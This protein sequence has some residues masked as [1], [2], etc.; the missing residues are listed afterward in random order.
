MNRSSRSFERIALIIASIVLT[1]L[2]AEAL[3]RLLGVAPPPMS[4]DSEA[5][6]ATPPGKRILD[7]LVPG[8]T[9][10]FQGI[11]YTLNRLG[12]RGPEYDPWPAPGD[13][14]IVIVGDSVTMGHG[15]RAG[16]TYPALVEASLNAK[17]D[18]RRY[19]VINLGLSNLNSASVMNRL[20][21]IGASYH[22]DLVVYGY[23][24]NDIEGTDYRNTVRSPDGIA[25]RR[26][27]GWRF[28]DSSSALARFLWPRLVDLSEILFVPRGSY[29]YELDDNYFDNPAAW[30]TV[31]NSLSRLARFA[32]SRRNCAHV[33]VHT[34]VVHINFHNPFIPIYEKV[35]AAAEAHGMT[36]TRSLPFFLGHDDRTL[37]VSAFD[38]HPNAAGHRLHA[39]ALLDGLA[40]LPASCW[41]SH[42]TRA[43][44]ATDAA[45]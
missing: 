30:S 43:S 27:F 36:V 11:E 7:I 28:R 1:C 42:L 38:P 22:P 10:T 35:A 15:V 31:D 25:Y 9:G 34:H 45:P 41:S 18:G 4:S 2:L 5:N 8:T 29:V 12:V 16:D 24:M 37:Q 19:E 6:A 40:A 39:Q 14:R 20:E 13:F 32:S 33:L 21:T 23:T 26:M 44:A 3:V 17:G